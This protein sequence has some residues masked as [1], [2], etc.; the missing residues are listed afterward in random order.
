MAASGRG[1]RKGA[2][3]GQVNSWSCTSRVACAR[4]GSGAGTA[5]ASVTGHAQ[6]AVTW[7]SDFRHKHRQHRCLRVLVLVLVQRENGEREREK[8]QR[9][10]SNG[11]GLEV[12]FLSLVDERKGGMVHL[13]S[14]CT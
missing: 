12:S 14:S 5:A 2:W 13:Y 7:D 6:L 4:A 3:R 1:G 11:C 9:E 10:I 8:G